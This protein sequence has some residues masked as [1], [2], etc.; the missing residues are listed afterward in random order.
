MVNKTIRLSKESVGK[1]VKAACNCPFDIDLRYGTV[2]V[3][4]KSI[5]GV[6]SLD[7][8]HSLIVS[9]AENDEMT[10]EFKNLLNSYAV[11]A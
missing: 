5:L 11:V 10:E 9:Y 2:V 3:D 4:A 7:L 1:F 6:Y 8:S